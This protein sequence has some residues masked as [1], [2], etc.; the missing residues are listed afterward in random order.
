[1]YSATIST[2]SV[3]DPASWLGKGF[4]TFDLDWA[5]DDVITDTVSL[6]EAADVSATWFVTHDTP[7]LRRLRTNPNF[8]LG[9]HPNFNWLLMGDSR[10]GKDTKEVVER[11]MDLVPEAKCVRSHSM[12]QSSGILDVFASAGL[13]HDVNHFIPASAGAELRPWIL[14][15]GITKVPYC[16]E[17]DVAC[18]YESRGA[19]EPSVVD[20]ATTGKGIKV[21]DFHPIHVF[22]NTEDIQRYEK[23]RHIHQNPKMLLK[24][25]F[26]GSGA[27]SR[28]Q[29]LLAKFRS[30]SAQ[31]AAK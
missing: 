19:E 1:M 16:W 20:V 21:F 14:W 29:E 2:I 7:V 24:H 28:L 13:T 10:N 31:G 18:I 6:L 3:N 17:D 15:N 23:T 22:L 8:E 25:R 26:D 9:I 5:H 12:L 27:R 11:M 4:I 30:G